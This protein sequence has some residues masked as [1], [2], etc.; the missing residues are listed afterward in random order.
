MARKKK[1]IWW[2]S[3]PMASGADEARARG[4]VDDPA[5]RRVRRSPYYGP[6]T[7]HAEVD[8]D[9]AVGVGG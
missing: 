4:A 9:D 2:E 5:H 3:E 7:L 1:L 8:D 6:V